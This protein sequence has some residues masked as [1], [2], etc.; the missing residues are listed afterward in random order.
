MA[1]DIL[2]IADRFHCGVTLEEV[3]AVQ[4]DFLCTFEL[5]HAALAVQE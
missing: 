1:S 3:R 4:A 2:F 5:Q